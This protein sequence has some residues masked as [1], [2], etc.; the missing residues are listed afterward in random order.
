MFVLL[1]II[2][3]NGV[4][5]G[6]DRETI[7]T[8]PADFLIA[9]DG[10]ARYCLELG[11]VP[12]LVIGDF[13]SLSADELENLISQGARVERHP[14]DKDETDLE[15]ALRAA[16]RQKADEVIVLG[17]LGERWDMSLAN[18]L[19]IA[20]PEF[21]RLRVRMLADGQQVMLV[22]PG[23]SC[24]LTGSPGDTVSL[25]PLRGNAHGVKTDGLKY[26]LGEETLEFGYTRGISNVLLGETAR[27]TLDSGLLLCVL[28]PLER[29][30]EV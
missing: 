16:K 5:T 15:L 29:K 11:L 10:G 1:S 18:V 28:V 9:A 2:L 26:S 19:L 7:R 3:A 13:D 12:Q 17:A 21:R 23:A 14:V 27:I 6:G 24:V 22:Q 8:T 4:L 30:R 25:L 20:H